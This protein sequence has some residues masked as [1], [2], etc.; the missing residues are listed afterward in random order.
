MDICVFCNEEITSEDAMIFCTSCGRV[1]HKECFECA[2]CVV[3]DKP[4]D[5]EELKMAEKDSERVRIEME[6]KRRVEEEIRRIEQAEN[7][8][9][10]RQEYLQSKRDNLKARGQDGYYEY[11]VISVADRKGAVNVERL[12]GILNELGLDGWRLKC[13]YTNELGVDSLQI[14]GFGI[15]STADQNVLILERFVKVW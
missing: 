13:A 5:D 8:Q 9:K 3:C 14:A 15:N 11:K 6:A 1:Y 7:N 2:G 4:V 12:M 10:A